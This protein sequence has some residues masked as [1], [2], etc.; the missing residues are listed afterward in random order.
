L[1]AV[2]EKQLDRDRYQVILQKDGETIDQGVVLLSTACRD[3]NPLTVTLAMTHLIHD[4]INIVVD[5]SKD[6][7]VWNYTIKGYKMVFPSVRLK[8]GT[9]SEPNQLILADQLEDPY[10]RYRAPGTHYLVEVQLET[11]TGMNYD[12]HTFENKMVYSLEFDAQKNLL[13]GEWGSLN[14]PSQD[15]SNSNSNSN[16][17]NGIDF[18]WFYGKDTILGPGIVDPVI[19]RKLYTCG[20]RQDADGTL[21]LPDPTTLRDREVTFNHCIL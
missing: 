5:G 11:M 13:G 7:S 10:Q 6:E 8:N 4:G 15:E 9:L 17:N 2:L 1:T 16:S 18:I 14:P 20:Q 19:L 12:G 3:T 21:I